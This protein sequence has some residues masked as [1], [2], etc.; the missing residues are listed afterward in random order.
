MNKTNR[1]GY[2]LVPPELI[3]EP[4]GQKALSEIF[5]GMTKM[6]KE[7]IMLSITGTSKYFDEIETGEKPPL[8]KCAIFEDGT[9]QIFR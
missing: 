4:N 1:R 7:N 2:I 6:S 9:F 3:N 8:Y 5:S